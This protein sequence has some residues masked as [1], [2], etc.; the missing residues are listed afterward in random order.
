VEPI[1][2]ESVVSTGMSPSLLVAGSTYDI[3]VFNARR[4][5]GVGS[6][7]GLLSSRAVK[8]LN[9]RHRDLVVL[10]AHARLAALRLRRALEARAVE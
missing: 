4:T 8:A 7:C 6:H 5:P 9:R 1:S 10:S 3:E 2:S